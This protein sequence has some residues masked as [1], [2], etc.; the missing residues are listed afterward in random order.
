L[1]NVYAKEE[2]SWDPLNCDG[3]ICIFTRRTEWTRRSNLDID[4]VMMG[5]LQN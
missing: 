5:F 4:D 3:R 2:G 1:Y